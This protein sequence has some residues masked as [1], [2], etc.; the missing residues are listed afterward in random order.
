MRYRIGIE[1]AK[2]AR[3]GLLEL[4]KRFR[5]S[6][7]PVMDKIAKRLAERIRSNIDAGQVQPLSPATL[8]MRRTRK[9]SPSTSAQ[10]LLDTGHM[11]SRVTTRVS[12]F[13]AQAWADTFYATFVQLGI[14]QT[15]GAIPGKRIP[16]RPFMVL[17]EGDVDW[18]AEMVMDYMTGERSA[19]A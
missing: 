15:S 2:E 3:E 14:K 12:E 8:R 5:G 4:G 1:G 10:P 18:A 13:V 17:D 16:P 9:A 7:R 11:K 6:K 19:A